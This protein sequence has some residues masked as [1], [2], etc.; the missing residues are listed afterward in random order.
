MT[1][2]DLGAHHWIGRMIFAASKPPNRMPITA[3]IRSTQI[4]RSGPNQ[5][6]SR[7]PFFVC[8]RNQRSFAS[9]SVQSKTIMLPIRTCSG[10]MRYEINRFRTET[11]QLPGEDSNLDQV[12]QSHS[13]YHYTIRQSDSSRVF[14][15]GEVY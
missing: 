14:R 13:C 15:K 5:R 10:I 4:A 6:I 7:W 9:S 3:K 12:I 2:L 8:S 11:A 1:Q